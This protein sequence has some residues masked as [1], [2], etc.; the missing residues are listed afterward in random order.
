VFCT[1]CAD[2]RTTSGIFDTLT[3]TGRAS[4]TY[5]RPREAG[6]SVKRAF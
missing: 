3:T 4:V 5:V 1:N 2:T 6:V